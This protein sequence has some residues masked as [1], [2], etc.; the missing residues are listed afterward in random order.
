VVDEQKTEGKAPNN[1]GVRL[2]LEQALG[3][4]KTKST[5]TVDLAAKVM[6]A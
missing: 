3:G 6:K 4:V 1:M 5:G 2:E